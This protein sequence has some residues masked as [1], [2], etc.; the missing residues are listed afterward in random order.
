[1]WP[2]YKPY[3][4]TPRV[5]PVNLSVILLTLWYIAFHR[6]LFPAEGNRPNISIN[7]FFTVRRA[8]LVQR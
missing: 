2:M 5:G 6:K 4:A 7:S 3:I 1:M 8:S